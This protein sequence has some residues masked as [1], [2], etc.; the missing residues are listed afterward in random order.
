[1]VSLPGYTTWDWIGL[2]ILAMAA[3]IGLFTLAGFG[4]R[5][6]H[7]LDICDAFRYQYLL[8]LGLGG[9]VAGGLASIGSQISLAAMLLAWFFAGVNVWVLFPLFRFRLDQHQKQTLPGAGAP[10]NLRLL[11][12]NI[13]RRNRAYQK[14]ID[15]VNQEK[16]DLIALVEPNQA[17]LESLSILRE[18]YPYWHSDPREDNYG[19][20]LLSRF[21]LRNQASV[22]LTD[23]GVPTLSAQV[24]L[25]SGMLTILVT[26]PPP[27]KNTPDL[28]WRDLQ[29]ERLSDMVCQRTGEPVVLCGDFNAV[30]WSKAFRRMALRAG[31]VDS[32]PGFGYQPTW[33]VDRPWLR[34]PIDH[35]LASPGWRVTGRR[36]GAAV[37]SDHLPLIVD[38]QQEE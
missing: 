31:L 35:C 6:H 27:P 13:L 19:L 11:S 7:Y 26:H 18:G 1:M 15:L 5:Y 23:K 24:D 32:S 2:L 8:L 12:V 25:P 22:R 4:A 33:P 10:P 9:L 37:G 30:P 36:I 20:A 3:G 16:P 17:W 21:P 28:H 38:F 34:V 14:M 29:M